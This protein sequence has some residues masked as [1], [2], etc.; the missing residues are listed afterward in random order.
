MANSEDKPYLPRIIP[1]G[2]FMAF[3]G[4]EE[5]LRFSG[6][7]GLV[8]L[9][10][11]ALLALYPLKALTVFFV[12]VYFS[13]RYSEIVLSDFK[14]AGLLAISTLWGLAV[15]FLWINMDWTAGSI[16]AAAGYNPLNSES[17]GMKAALIAFRVFGAV[18]VVPIMEELFWR[19]FLLR[20]IIDSKFMGVQIGHFTFPSFLISSILFGLEHSFIFAGIMAGIAYNLL[21][22]R[23]KSIACC[24]VSH[25]VTNLALAIYVLLTGKWHFW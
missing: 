21:L 3:I 8:S 2:L 23:T 20:Y 13:R 9:S 24:I 18:I 6:A 5:V 22:Y 1:F 16:G 25:S 14:R 15:F 12:L 4:A 10:E 19:S 11:Q 7:K 17:P